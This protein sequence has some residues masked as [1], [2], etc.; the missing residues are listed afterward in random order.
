MA[1]RAR[2]RVRAAARHG[3]RWS[4][5]GTRAPTLGIRHG[6]VDVQPGGRGG[7]VGGDR[8]RLHARRM[9][10]RQPFVVPQPGCRSRVER[11]R[12][13]GGLLDHRAVILLNQDHSSHPVLQPQQIIVPLLLPVEIHASPVD[14]KVMAAVGIRAAWIRI[15]AQRRCFPE[16]R[17]AERLDSHHRDG[18]AVRLTAV[19]SRSVEASASVNGRPAGRA[20]VRSD[21]NGL[22]ACAVHGPASVSA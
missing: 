2:L 15:E 10:L 19:L 4:T 7:A 14:N 17:R 9:A 22:S 18:A 16:C 1:S 20:D 6:A 12:L 3:L 11:D 5:Q 21:F 8:R 13:Y